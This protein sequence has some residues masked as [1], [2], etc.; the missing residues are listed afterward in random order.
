MRI[1]GG[2]LM[3]GSVASGPDVFLAR[4][5]AIHEG[6]TTGWEIVRAISFR[7]LR[8]RRTSLT[9]E[10]TPSK[11]STEYNSWGCVSCRIDRACENWTELWHG[12]RTR[13]S[14]SG[15]F[16][17]PVNLLYFV[18]AILNVSA[19]NLEKFPGWLQTPALILDACNEGARRG[20]LRIY[21]CPPDGGNFSPTR[22]VYPIHDRTRVTVVMIHI[23]RRTQYRHNPPPPRRSG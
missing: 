15:R 9:A 21:P 19:S 18:V 17:P 1:P 16:Q 7:V 23:G 3:G 5:S 11:S 12:H 13:A 4:T 8:G 14:P 22:L 2:G 6:A 20:P 10:F